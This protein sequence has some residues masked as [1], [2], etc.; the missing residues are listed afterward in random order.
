MRL[1]NEVR[2]SCPRLPEPGADQVLAQVGQ[3]FD[4]RTVRLSEHTA[5]TLPLWA[6]RTLGRTNMHHQPLGVGPLRA[7]T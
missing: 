6:E 4:E 3:A 5:Q 1:T 7:M 2:S